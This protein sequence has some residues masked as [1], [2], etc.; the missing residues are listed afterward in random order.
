[1]TAFVLLSQRLWKYN[2]TDSYRAE[3]EQVTHAERQILCTA[4][5]MKENLLLRV[6]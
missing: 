5:E 1:M 6:S 3:R 2:G 4:D